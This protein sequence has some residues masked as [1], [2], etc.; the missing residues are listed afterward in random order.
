MDVAQGDEVFE[1]EVVSQHAG[2]FQIRIGN[3]AFG[4][5]EGD[6]LLLYV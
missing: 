6:H 2:H 4:V 3:G 5:G 1:D